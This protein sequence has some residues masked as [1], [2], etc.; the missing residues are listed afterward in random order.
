MIASINPDQKVRGLLPNP[1]P[2]ELGYRMPAEWH[3]HQ[4]TWFSWPHNLDTWSKYLE[5]TEHALA[6]AVHWLSQGE[7]VHIN[8][9]DEAH[10]HHVSE[11]LL[12]A[13]AN[14]DSVY[15]HYFPTNDAWCR[16]HGAVFLI[17]SDQSSLAAIDWRYNAWGEKYPPFDLDNAVPRQMGEALTVTRF[18]TPIVL[19]GGSIEVNG[20]GVL[21]T[22]DTCLLNP[23]RNPGLKKEEIAI[24]LQEM[25]GIEDILWLSGEL[26]GDDTDGHIDNLARFA[27]ETTIVAPEAAD[28]NDENFESLLTNLA[29]LKTWNS[30]Q[31]NRFD[32]IQIPMPSPVF[33]EGNR[34]PANY[35][36]FYIGNS[37]VLM[38]SFGDPMDETAE[39]ILQ[40]CFKERKVVRID[41]SSVIWGLGAIHCLTQQV[42]L[43]TPDNIT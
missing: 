24:V 4:G 32:I 39:A 2:R 30:T 29:L 27:N 42:P 3:K 43:P 1:T 22:T 11:V 20:A 18:E 10:K 16:D 13:S 38:P 6:D 12:L 25:L 5:P 17:S 21:L 35:M 36:N 37:V 9:L 19:E 26:V 33:I 8:V 23:N 31:N 15:F 28:P 34:M 14:M 41:C 40:S 7:A